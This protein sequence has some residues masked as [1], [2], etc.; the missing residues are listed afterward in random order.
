M[1]IYI[2][3]AELT[4][5]GAQ[6]GE[7]FTLQAEEAAKIRSQHGGRLIA[8]YVTFGRYDLLFITEYPNQQEA[9][10]AVEANTEKGRY[11]YEVAEAITLED[12]LKATK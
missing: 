11:T 2:I 5:A 9:T 3:G 1:P 10:A 6:S 12:F 4:D 8:A 7:N